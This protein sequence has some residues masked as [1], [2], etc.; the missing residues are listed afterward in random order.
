M[1]KIFFVAIAATL[2]AAGCQKTEV[3]NQVIPDGEPSMSYAPSMGKLTK[4]AS[5]DGLNTLQGQDFHLWAYYVAADPNRGAAANSVYDGMA[6]IKVDYNNGA[7]STNPVHF[8]PGTGK[9]LKFFAVSADENISTELFADNNIVPDVTAPGTDNYVEATS[10]YEGLTIK[11]FTVNP[12]NPTSDLMVADYLE[13]DQSTL[14]VA[15]N[16]RHALSK[17]QFLFKNTSAAAEEGKTPDPKTQV[18]VQ[19]VEVKKVSNVGSLTVAKT[20]TSAERFA[21]KPSAIA[22]FVAQYKGTPATDLQIAPNGSDP[23]ASNYSISNANYMKLTK[24]YTEYATW[25]VIPQDVQKD[26]NG[27]T[28]AIDLQ[29]EIV[30]V[31]GDRQFVSQFPLSTTT[32]KAWAP[33]QYIK[34]NINLSPNIIGFNP[35]V[36]EWAPSATGSDTNINE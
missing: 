30:Y 3:I 34:Y 25:L 12:T 13:Q 19:H 8:W 7:W 21:W 5:V 17:V 24:D 31:I 1:K 33:N 27:P 11:S 20:S 15:L 4:A 28:D 26:G 36:E 35:T 29:V 10:N 6:N 14:D 9:K 32:L 18:W 22:T 16:F 2:L 23:K